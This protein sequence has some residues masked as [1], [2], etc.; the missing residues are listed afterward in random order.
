[1]DYIISGPR[2]VLAKNEDNRAA[3]QEKRRAS[4]TEAC[5][6][7][8]DIGLRLAADDDAKKMQIYNNYAACM[9]TLTKPDPAVVVK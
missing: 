3:S 2:G 9:Q 1:M 8:R 5:M 6:Q 7:A 4:V